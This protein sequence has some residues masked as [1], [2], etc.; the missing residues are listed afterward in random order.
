VIRLF[1]ITHKSAS[2]EEILR[3]LFLHVAPGEVVLVSGSVASGKS[4]LLRIARGMTPPD[5]G[6]V[7]LG[8]ATPSG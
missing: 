7:V 1:H 8:G 6:T 5:K 4:T 3:D 2:G